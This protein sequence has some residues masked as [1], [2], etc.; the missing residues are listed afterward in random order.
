MWL[1][2]WSVWRVIAGF[3]NR[4]GST[5]ALS[6]PQ[7]FGSAA[8]PNG[9]TLDFSRPGKPTGNAFIESFTGSVR[10]ECLNANAFVS[11]D[12]AKEN[13]EGLRVDYNEHRP[14]PLWAT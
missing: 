3:P 13:I 9:V 10:A 6:S 14:T 11:I 1:P 4:F 5:M 12:D 7:G 2:S 8:Y